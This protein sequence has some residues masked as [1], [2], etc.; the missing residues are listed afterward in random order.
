M[1]KYL[2]LQLSNNPEFEMLI[3]MESKWWLYE[4]SLKFVFQLSVY[5]TFLVKIWEGEHSLREVTFSVDCHL[6]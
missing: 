4:C 2:H 1:L 6:S 5:L 3:I